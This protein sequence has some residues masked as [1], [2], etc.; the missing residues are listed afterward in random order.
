MFNVKKYVYQE[1]E[2]KTFLCMFMRVHVGVPMH[3]CPWTCTWVWKPES[4]LSLCSGTPS[5][6]FEPFVGQMFTY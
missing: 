6:S 5:T 1:L 2:N 4:K 3:V